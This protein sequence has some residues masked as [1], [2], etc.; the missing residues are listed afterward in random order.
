MNRGGKKGLSPVVATVLLIAMVV[1]IGIIIFLWLK[2]LTKEVIT[3]N[4]GGADKN[5]QVV[6]DEVYF[7]ADYTASGRLTILNSGNVPIY[8]FKVKLSS[9]GSYSTENLEDLSSLWESDFETGLNPGR[10]F[11][12]IVSLSGSEATIIPVL[13]GESE[14]GRKTYT[15]NEDLHGYVITL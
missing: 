12:D 14:K 9:D 13:I 1:V 7:E 11:S 3:K 4:I 15:C 2:G 10:V 5:V 8:K 6:C